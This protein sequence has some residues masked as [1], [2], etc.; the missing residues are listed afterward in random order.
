MQFLTRNNHKC[1]Q[2][3]III[4]IKHSKPF[5]INF[6]FNAT[7]FISFLLTFIFRTRSFISPQTVDCA[8]ML[9]NI[10][11]FDSIVLPCEAVSHC[12]NLHEFHT[13]LVHLT[14]DSFIVTFKLFSF[15]CL[16]LGCFSLLA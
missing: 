4:H 15:L 10:S 13:V 11:I 8:T 6:R 5:L 9:F 12:D 16:C 2:K 14:F 1:K 3:V 7:S